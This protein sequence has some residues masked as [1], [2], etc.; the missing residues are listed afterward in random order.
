MADLEALRERIERIEQELFGFT[1]KEASEYLNK[2][3]ED[4]KRLQ[5]VELDSYCSLN[6]ET[7]K[8]AEKC[9]GA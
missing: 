1:F 2:V 8:K 6:L 7:I 9:V 5:G 4:M 3:N